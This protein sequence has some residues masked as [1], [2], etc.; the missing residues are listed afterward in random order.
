MPLFRE[1]RFLS[2]TKLSKRE[3]VEDDPRSGRSVSSTNDKNM[4]FVRVV[5]AKH[6]RLR[7]RM[8]AEETGLNRNA[9]H[10][11][12]T[13][14]LFMRKI[15]AKVVPKNISV[16]QKVNRLEICQDLLGRLEIQPDV[17]H[18]VIT[19][20]ESWVFDYDPEIKRQSAEWHTKSSLRPTK[21]RMSRSRV[22]TMIIVF[23]T[24][25][26]LCTKNLYLEDRQLIMPSTEM[27]WNDFKNGSSESERTLQTT[28]CCTIIT[29]QLI[30]RFQFEN[31]WWR[32]TCPYF[33]ILPT[34]Q[35]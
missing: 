31:F 24:A 16:E 9:V 29:R 14:H 10:R 2:G 1:L 33:H 26:A 25:M 17:L 30:L 21:A 3:N 22:K 27:S 15:C 12:L 13:D 20:A 11:I 18:K 5:I 34:D 32:K 8:I 23:S 19:G 28:G 4:E 7:F 6:R 35:I